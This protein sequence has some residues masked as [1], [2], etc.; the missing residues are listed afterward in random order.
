M[1]SLSSHNLHLKLVIIIEKQTVNT[2][3]YYQLFERT[4]ASKL[5]LFGLNDTIFIAKYP[6]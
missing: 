5:E 1:Q 3:Y 6:Y 4:I 2:K